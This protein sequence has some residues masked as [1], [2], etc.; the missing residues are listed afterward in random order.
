MISVVFFIFN[1]YFEP[2]QTLEF[3]VIFGS[4]VPRIVRAEVTIRYLVLLSNLLFKCFAISVF[5]EG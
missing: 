3:S 1:F 5:L 2:L 4:E